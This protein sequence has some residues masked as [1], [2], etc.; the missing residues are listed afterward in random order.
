MNLDPLLS[1]SPAI[2]LHA[3][4]AMFAFGL[5]IVQL[6]G[7][8]GTTTHR[9]LG[10]TWSIAMLAVAVSS[11][12]IN[13]M[14]QFG[15]FSWIHI[16]SISVLFTVPMA[17]LAARRHNV[18]RHRTAMIAIFVGALVIAGFFTFVP[19]RIMHDVVFPQ[20]TQQAMR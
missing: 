3:F 4:A 19:G 8:K 12:W 16:L 1:A 14:R 18:T 10:W 7:P 2:I 20:G 13:D 5:G 17:L 15:N 9:V 6:A 11:F